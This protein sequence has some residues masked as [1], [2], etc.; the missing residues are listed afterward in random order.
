M[1]LLE[2]EPLQKLSIERQ[3]KAFKHDGYWRPVD[4]IRELEILEKEMDNNFFNY[5][6]AFNPKV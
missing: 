2:R 5:Y 6:D 1:T 3:L 4:T